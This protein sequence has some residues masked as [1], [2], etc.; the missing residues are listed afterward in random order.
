MARVGLVLGAGG[1]TGEAFHA[2]ALAAIEETTG[3]D[4]RDADIITGT[5]A[6]S[7]VGTFLRHGISTAD[8][9]AHLCDEPVSERA[10]ASLARM[11]PEPGMVR[12][13]GFSLPSLPNASTLAR[14]ARGRTSLGVLMASGAPHGRIEILP[15]M[16]RIQRAVGP[17]WVDDPLWICGVR[18]RDG[19]R[20]VFG[21]EDAPE[22]D[23][24]DA[25]AAS[26]AIPGIFRPVEIHGDLYVDGG[27]HSPTNADV[28]RREDL[29]LVIVLSPMSTRRGVIRPLP[30]HAPRLGYRYQL[31]REARR[32]REAGMQVM[33]FQPDAGD[34]AVMRGNAMNA[35]KIA[36]VIRRVRASV[37]ANLPH[38]ELVD[39]LEMAS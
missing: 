5:S 13:P 14:F 10:E 15:F 26:C 34:L 16:Q 38:R 1:L 19:R 32:L 23:I 8:F 17:G 28:L 24:E 11:G 22:V 4:P 12:R 7:I 29:D 35:S 25:L 27:A 21:R 33:T 39:A 31:G 30:D 2:G 3:W 37:A 18:L 6:G 20:V 9:A 36:P